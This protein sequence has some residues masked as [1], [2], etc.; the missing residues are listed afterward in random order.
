[1]VNKECRMICIGN[2]WKSF[3]A[4]RDEVISANFENQLK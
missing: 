2:R 4:N 3:A 1:M